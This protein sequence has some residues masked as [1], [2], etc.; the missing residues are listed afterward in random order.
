MAQDAIERFDFDGFISYRHSPRQAAVARALQ[1]ALQRFARPLFKRRA[2]RLYR[3][4]T[5]LGA[6]P[7]LWGTI[8]AAMERSRFFLLMA[9]PEAAAS[10]WVRRELEHWLGRHGSER[11]IVVLTD[12]G[13][14][15]D[16]AQGGFDPSASDAIPADL[17]DA[18]DVEPLYVDLSWA[19]EPQRDLV[20]SNPRFLDSV[21][22]IAAALHGK[23]KD[24][25]FGADLKELRRRQTLAGGA[26]AAIA[27]A[28]GIAVVAAFN[29]FEQRNEARLQRDLAA[30]RQLAT[31][32]DLALDQAPDRALLLAV[33]AVRARPTFEA[34]RALGRSLNRTMGLER[35]EHVEAESWSAVELV[36]SGDA[37][38]GVDND[39]RVIR[40]ALEGSGEIETFGSLSC[41]I[42]TA[43]LDP[44]GAFLAAACNDGML[45][46]EPLVPDAE[47]RE[48]GK[49][50]GGGV[51]ALAI[52]GDGSLL[53]ISG[54]VNTVALLSLPEGRVLWRQGVLKNPPSALAFSPDSDALWI[55]GEDGHLAR[56][57]TSGAEDPKV[58]RSRLGFVTTLAVSRESGRIA[59]GDEQ[60]RLAVWTPDQP[61][62]AVTPSR[63][64]DAAIRAL[65]FSPD[66]AVLAVGTDDGGVALHS[67]AYGSPLRP[68]VEIHRT[69][70]TTLTFSPDG[71]QFLA[72]GQDRL[73]TVWAPDRERSALF[74][75]PA[76]IGPLGP[77][78]FTGDGGALLTSEPQ[79]RRL[80]LHPIDGAAPIPL[81][82]AA[83]H[84]PVLAVGIVPSGTRFATA[85]LDGT[86]IFW[87]AGK[88]AIERKV[89]MPAPPA[90]PESEGAPSRSG[91][92]DDPVRL[93]RVSSSSRPESS[94]IGASGVFLA[95]SG[96][97]P[98]C[99]LRQGR[100]VTAGF[101][102]PAE[103]A[104][105]LDSNGC[106]RLW[107]E[108]S[109]WQ[110]LAPSGRLPSAKNFALSPDGKHA[111]IGDSSGRVIWG[112]LDG[113]ETGY[114][115]GSATLTYYYDLVFTPE[116]DALLL[117]GHRSGRHP[118]RSRLSFSSR[119]YGVLQTMA[120][121][122]APA[123]RIGS[124][125]IWDSYRA[126]AF[127]E[128]ADLFVLGG[129][130]SSDG[131]AC[132]PGRV[133]IYDLAV[134][135]PLWS[136]VAP[137]RGPVRT[138]AFDRSGERLAVLTADPSVFA[139]L[140]QDE[141]IVYDLTPQAW[142]RAACAIA[143]RRLTEQ[144]IARFLG[145][146]P[147][148]FLPC[149]DD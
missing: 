15:W 30:S 23:A 59:A 8:V 139:G 86:L 20:R 46:I 51:A 68:S 144:E 141:V 131:I 70:V 10:K 75:R 16:A 90:S 98:D 147:E 127:N 28:G 101:D 67:G 37:L 63:V 43:A 6:N 102:A 12:G 55:G 44:S 117:A 129:C 3:D 4:E 71:A 76:V 42:A 130:Q 56:L 14:S 125:P 80:V 118:D 119:Q 113:S 81:E 121:A 105:F 83:E 26:V 143:N 62:G 73:V 116:S 96:P 21:A 52:S 57:V 128:A 13:L 142:R 137:G 64:G 47:G 22:T 61:P 34:R 24:E 108:D 133:S 149:V 31:Q 109:G 72:G 74:W 32:A 29:F 19:V 111:V 107:R 36:P 25:I 145:G 132:T 18:F 54:G 124:L 138:L 9:S 110:D 38:V 27:L 99:E 103:T 79:N 77:M 84:G 93:R 146:L 89:T 60:G 97:P 92:R 78:A 58:R 7:D 91:A 33:S 122:D 115:D 1:T 11:L 2:V 120:L 95:M 135:E 65:R 5:N 41:P 85:H 148:D 66:D 104:A 53:A 87:D 94:G 39:G 136:D 88:Q 134:G 100:L 112:R 114:E 48:L 17:L 126:I 45:R 49:P 140:K 69:A 40:R 123:P 50:V 82:Q 106:L 35:F